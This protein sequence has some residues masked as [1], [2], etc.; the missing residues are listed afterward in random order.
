MIRFRYSVTDGPLRRD[1]YIFFHP[2]VVRGVFY[3]LYYGYD[4]MAYVYWDFGRNIPRHKITIIEN[5]Y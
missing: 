4:I 1:V 3:F 2:S 5:I